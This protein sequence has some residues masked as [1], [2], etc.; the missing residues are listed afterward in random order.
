MGDIRGI[1]WTGDAY[2]DALETEVKTRIG[3]SLN[4]QGSY[5]WGKAI[6]T[7]SATVIGD[8]FQTSISS[9]YFFCTKC[10]RSLSDFNIAQSLSAHLIWDLPSPKNWGAIGSQVLGGWEI[11]SIITAQ[12]GVPF[13]PT[14]TGDV[15]GLG[16]ADP[17]AFPSLVPGCNPIN[18][19]FKRNSGSVLYYNPSCFAFPLQ[20]TIPDV[21]CNK[22]V[23]PTTGQPGCLNLFGNVKR[24]SL[25]GPKLVDVDFSAYKNFP[26][27][28]ISESFNVQFRAELF[29]ILNHANFAPPI[30]NVAVLQSNVVGTANVGSYVSNAGLID[31][32]TTT[33][34]QIQFGLKVIW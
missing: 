9:P 8:P 27:R 2:Y 3:S 6:D 31:R 18:S 26:V 32:T 19:N 20:G 13:T 21:Q 28:A 17:W 11:G 12:T 14:I 10:R 33:S 30:N 16:S 22:V 5:T 25:V 1:Y 4:V 24:N 7:G 34:R 23:N 29:N 15:L